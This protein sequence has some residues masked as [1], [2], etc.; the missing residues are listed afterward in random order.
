MALLSI[1][2]ILPRRTLL[3]A[4]LLVGLLAAERGTVHAEAP[5]SASAQAGPTAIFPGCIACTL[6]D[7]T[8]VDLGPT[9]GPP[10]VAPLG[11][12][13]IGIQNNGGGPN[14]CASNVHVNAI[15]A[16][17]AGSNTSVMI[18][19]CLADGGGQG[20]GTLV[21]PLGTM[22]LVQVDFPNQ[23]SETNENNNALLIKVS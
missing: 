3:I 23:I 17:W 21:A 20:T 4:L 6:S 5:R 10:G 18:I 8:V 14:Q 19:P 22:V 2:G 9:S 7:L 11:Y 16:V 12:H 15:G 1:G 13:L